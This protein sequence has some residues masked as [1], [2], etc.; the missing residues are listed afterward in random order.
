MSFLNDVVSFGKKAIGLVSDSGI[1]SSIAK[2]A[3]LGF[4]INYINNSIGKDNS[5]PDTARSTQPDRFVREQLSPNT[6]HSI[7]VLYGESYI[8][9]IITDAHLESNNNT[10]Y[11]A[12][13]ICEKTG[14]LLSDS[15]DSVISF[16]EVWR[17]S[18]RLDF[19]SDG[20]TVTSGTDAS[21]NTNTKLNG[22]I[23][24][25]C[26][27]N[28]SQNPVVPDGYTNL[29]LQSAYTIFPTWTSNYQMNELVFAIIKITYSKENDVTNLGDIEFKLS[30]SMT[31]PGDVMLD[32]M[33]NT[34][35][36]AGIPAGEIYDS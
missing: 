32:Y 2:T 33:Q 15:S 35:Y 30:N 7:P 5:V 14:T 20:I 36:G 29:A 21:G 27:N 10:M 6:D 16:L 26:Y 24:V 34:R 28:G 8:K 18:E 4:L 9:G 19:D 22:L 17:N 23:E 13:T 12:I 1:G 11:Y 25:Y 3:A 31:L